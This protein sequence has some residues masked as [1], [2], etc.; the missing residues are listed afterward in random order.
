LETV[1]DACL[2]LDVYPAPRPSALVRI[3]CLAVYGLKVSGLLIVS[4]CLIIGDIRAL[5]VFRRL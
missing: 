1:G 5:I 3:L 2:Y 4:R